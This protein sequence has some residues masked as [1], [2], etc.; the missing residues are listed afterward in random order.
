MVKIPASPVER[1]GLEAI[2]QLDVALDLAAGDLDS[3]TGWIRSAGPA[4][5]MAQN[6]ALE[7]TL[8]LIAAEIAALQGRAAEAAALRLD[9]RAAARYGFGAGQY[10]AREAEI[11]RLG[12]LGR[13]GL[14]G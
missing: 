3:A 2:G 6:P 4:L 10:A 13:Q 14:Q 9:T 1:L 5:P 8:G 7:A 12:N 11:A